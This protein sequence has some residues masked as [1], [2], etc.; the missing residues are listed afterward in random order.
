MCCLMYYINKKTQDKALCM[1][2]SVNVWIV[3]KTKIYFQHEIF[4][5]CLSS[6][7]G[8]ANQNWKWIVPQTTKPENDSQS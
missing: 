4:F 8:P 6:N 5:S 3:S 2:I 1:E 7:R